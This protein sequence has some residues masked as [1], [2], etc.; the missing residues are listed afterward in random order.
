MNTLIERKEINYNFNT[1]YNLAYDYESP[2]LSKFL[3][4]N[5]RESYFEILEALYNK[6]IEFNDVFYVYQL[7]TYF[8]NDEELG[9]LAKFELEEDPANIDRIIRWTK[10]ERLSIEINDNIYYFTEDKYQI[11]K[12][13][14]DFINRMDSEKRQLE[15][16][17]NDTDRRH[18][19]FSYYVNYFYLQDNYKMSYEE[20]QNNMSFTSD[21]Y[22][23]KEEF[24]K[25]DAKIQNKKEVTKKNK[26]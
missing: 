3:R 1:I 4:G 24:D 5:C 17:A 16:W 14:K 26:I 8:N 9:E 19:N 2:E 25:L 23:K 18:F 15:D 7:D 12:M 10:E 21:Y 6:E 13:L 20:F 11:E 22:T